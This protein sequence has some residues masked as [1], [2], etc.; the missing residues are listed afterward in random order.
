MWTSRQ[1]FRL[2]GTYISHTGFRSDEALAG[3]VSGTQGYNPFLGTADASYTIV[4]EPSTALLFGLAA[5]AVFGRR[6]RN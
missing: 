2:L 1:T 6:R 5:L 4:P 3:N